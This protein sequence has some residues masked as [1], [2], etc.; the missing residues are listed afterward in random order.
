MYKHI[1][2]PTDGSELSEKAIKQGLALAK[3][4]GAKVTAITISGTSYV[5]RM[6]RLGDSNR[7]DLCPNRLRQCE[8]LLD[9]LFRELRAVRRN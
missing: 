9:G 2:I 8:P 3:S 1:L 6:K 5:L 7:G 4:I